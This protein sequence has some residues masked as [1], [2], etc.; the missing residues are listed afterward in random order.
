MTKKDNTSLLTVTGLKDLFAI[1]KKPLSGLMV[2]EKV[3][4]AY[5]AL[6]TILVLFLYTRMSDPSAIL[7][8][9]VRFLAMTLALWGVYRLVPCRL[10]LGIRGVV[11]LA[12]LG[13][14]YPETYDFNRLFPNLDHLFAQWEQQLFGCQPALLFSQVLPSHVASELFDMGY[15]SYYFMIAVTAMFYFAFRYREFE[16]ATF[17]ILASFFIYYLIYIFLPVVGP[18]FYYHAVGLKTIA[19]GV[20]P[21][22]HDYFLTHTASLPSPGYTDGVFYQF[23]EDAKAAGERPTAAF[24]SSHVGVSTICM[25]LAWHSGNRRLFFVYLPFYIF[26]CCATVYIQ[27]HY[28]IDAIAGLITGVGLYFL[29]MWLSRGMERK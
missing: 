25:L 28:L 17:V 9:R 6:T 8:A 22:V 1:E 24:P 13:L 11:Q 29:M 18:T 20:F 3:A 4:I 16:R 26:L 21:N 12:L 7:M 5:A 10:M 19:E 15:G 2:F 23:V 27:A 14:W